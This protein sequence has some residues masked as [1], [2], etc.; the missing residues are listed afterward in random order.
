MSRRSA[1]AVLCKFWTLVSQT[2][3]QGVGTPLQA[4]QGLAKLPRLGDP[5]IPQN[6]QCLLDPFSGRQPGTQAKGL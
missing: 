1:K 2:R 5:S 3:N 4:S 6:R